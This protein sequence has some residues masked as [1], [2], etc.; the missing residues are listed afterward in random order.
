MEP[1]QEKE[2]AGSEQQTPTKKPLFTPWRVIFGLLGLLFLLSFGSRIFEEIRDSYIPTLTPKDNLDNYVGRRVSITGT[3]KK[4]PPGSP[5][6]GF[7]Q[8]GDEAMTFFAL[9]SLHELKDRDTICLT[10]NVLVPNNDLQP[11]GRHLLC[12][13]TARKVRKAQ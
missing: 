10:G 11:P 8:F 13:A 9:H 4:C 5:K 1:E 12:N 2:M 7:I 6:A 3:Y